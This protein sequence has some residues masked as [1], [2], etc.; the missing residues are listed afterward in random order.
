M[1]TF[2]HIKTQH[3]FIMERLIKEIEVTLGVLC[4]VIR[5]FDGNFTAV[6]HKRLGLMDLATEKLHVCLTY[7]V[8]LSN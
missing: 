8:K 5:C 1:L 7:L 3:C 2:I 4:Y 6:H